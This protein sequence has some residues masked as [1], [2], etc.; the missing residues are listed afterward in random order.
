[1]LPLSFTASKRSKVAPAQAAAPPQVAGGRCRALRLKR[2][3]QKSFQG[4]RV[5]ARAFVTS[6]TS[7]VSDNFLMVMKTAGSLSVTTIASI[8]ALVVAEL[9]PYARNR[10]ITCRLQK[11]AGIS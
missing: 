7:C 3:A 6:H 4:N 11:I 1:M 9:D 5:G 8:E 2:R 10:E